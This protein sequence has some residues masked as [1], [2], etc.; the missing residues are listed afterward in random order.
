MVFHS[1]Y[2]LFFKVITRPS[3]R[4]KHG[5]DVSKPENSMEPAEPDF[6]YSAPTQAL[7][8]FFESG[9]C[10]FGNGFGLKLTL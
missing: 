4:L 7:T 10:C 1:S 6:R 5:F 2:V 8:G 9:L 3:E